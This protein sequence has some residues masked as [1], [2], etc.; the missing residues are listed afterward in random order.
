MPLVTPGSQ[1]QEIDYSDI[2]PP[3]MDEFK[4]LIIANKYEIS[5]ELAPY[6]CLYDPEVIYLYDRHCNKIG[7]NFPSKGY[8]EYLDK[9]G[10]QPKIAHECDATGWYTNQLFVYFYATDE[11]VKAYEEY[12]NSL[13]DYEKRAYMSR[14]RS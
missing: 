8:K 11:D 3:E 13:G 4:R 1:I 14:M 5:I 6:I 9:L 10:L 2:D 12:V 7:F